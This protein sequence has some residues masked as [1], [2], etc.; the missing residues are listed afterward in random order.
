[1][2]QSLPGGEYCLPED[3]KR[4]ISQDVTISVDG[5]QMPA[6]LAR[7]E[8]NSGAHPAVI[9]LQEVF[10]FTP[11]VKRVTDLLASTGYVGLAIDYY[12]RDHSRFSAPYTEQGIKN[13]FEAA[14]GVTAQS[15]IAD[16]SAAISWL[17]EQS[18]VRFGNIA[19]WG[20]GFGAT[21]A[22]ASASLRELS[23]AICFYPGNVAAPMPAGGDPPI[24]RAEDVAVPLLLAFGEKD[25]YVSRFD[26]DRIYTSL[27]Q[28]NSDFRM[29]IYPNVGHSFFRHGSPAAIAE[30]QR[31]SDESVA[32]AVADSWD[33][34]RK[35]LKDCFATSARRAAETG[36]IHT[37][38]TQPLQP[39]TKR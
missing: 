36:E 30:Q 4:M 33:L 11:E 2:L 19:T 3:E 31:Y 37:A 26:M 38:R 28:A 7:P 12:H 10:G 8:E 5:S 29:Q 35:F 34:V 22:F 24:E 25:Y 21:L 17:N 15:A 27:K 20:F 18:F 39:Q 32:Q 9:V 14:A 6:Y 23:G 1:M 13:A 16:V